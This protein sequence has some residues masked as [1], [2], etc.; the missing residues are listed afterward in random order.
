[1]QNA[2]KLGGIIAGLMMTI[3]S[4]QAQVASPA[5]RTLVNHTS[6]FVQSAR[7]MGPADPSQTADV[8]IWLQ[9]HN[10][11]ALDNLAA[12]LYNPQSPLYHAWLSREAFLA[13]YAPT[14]HEVGIVTQFLSG[15]GLQVVS[16]GPANLYVRAHGSIGTIATAF[17]VNIHN[18]N[19]N[20]QVFYANENDPTIAGEAA[21][22]V[23]SISGLDN[24]TYEHHVLVQGASGKSGSTGLQAFSSGVVAADVPDPATA[25]SA[26]FGNG[27]VTESYT[28][29]TY[30]RAVYTGLPYGSATS[31]GCGYTPAQIQA[32]YNLNELYARGF[33]GSGQTIV[34]I[35]WCGSPTVQDDAN[36]FS[37]QFGLPPLTSSNFSIVNYPTPSSCAAEDIEINLDV[38]WAHAIA[39]GANITL[40]VPPSSSFQDTD[41]AQLY[42]VVQG[43]GSVISGSYGAEERNISAAELDNQNLIAE[44][45]ATF[46]IAENFSTGDS[47]DFTFDV[48]SNPATVSMPA[49]SPYNTGVG[50][51]TLALNPDNSIRFQTGWGNNRTLLAEQSFVYNPPFH[52]GFVY[53]SG[54]GASGVFAKPGYQ[55]ALPG[56]MRRLPDVSWLADP[57]TGAIILISAP[58]V[59]PPQQYE[60]IGGTSLSCPMFSALWA[61]ANQEA[62][63]SLGQ[64]APYLYTMPGGTLYDIV[65]YAGPNNVFGTVYTA[66][67]FATFYTPDS[68]AAPLNGT[69]TYL[70]AIWDYPTLAV[71]NT[72]FVLTFGTDT[73]LQTAPGWDNVTGVGVPN[74][75]AFADSFGSS[76]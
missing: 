46:G 76:Q 23:R 41:V 56:T 31:P 30:P 49:A 22:L 58:F 10:R 75:G 67:N 66:P 51:V 61:I 45:G 5:G 39:P 9:L 3:F 27:P 17:T 16:T 1:M 12:N 40:L 11:P 6:G 65:P 14:A 37:A 20:G 15:N 47:G 21:A 38:E 26:C 71:A 68:L 57:Y 48:A 18:Y 25:F 73:S 72:H 36:A 53:G 74:G 42:A 70:S 63:T 62:G 43:L 69:T 59:F 34:I 32:A 33:D 52:E 50:G 44:I 64:A 7:K 60:V 19:R 54:G 29:A 35:D 28:P 13:N 4:A 24:F 2:W 8:T 55:A